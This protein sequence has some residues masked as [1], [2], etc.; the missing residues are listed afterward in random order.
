MNK[1]LE[2]LGEYVDSII[3]QKLANRPQHGL[4]LQ[5]LT[6]LI[7]QRINAVLT[8]QGLRDLDPQHLTQLIDDRIA[9]HIVISTLQINKDAMQQ[10]VFEALKAHFDEAGVDMVELAE[11]VA[12]KLAKHEALKPGLERFVKSEMRE[13]I[14]EEIVEAVGDHLKEN[15]SDLERAVANT[16]ENEEELANK[17]VGNALRGFTITMNDFRE[18]L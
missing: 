17:M 12:E 9:H 4:D 11:D 5:H 13:V 16:F 1:I 18:S 15:E 2:A 10:K 14:R 8:D 7:D 3:E 6:N